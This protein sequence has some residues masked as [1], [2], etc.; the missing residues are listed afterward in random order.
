[1]QHCY[2]ITD[3]IS[4]PTIRISTNFYHML[5]SSIET[6]LQLCDDQDADIRMTSEECLSRI[7]RVSQNYQIRKI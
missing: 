2:I 6:F 7:I 1:M 3:A 4:N 5:G